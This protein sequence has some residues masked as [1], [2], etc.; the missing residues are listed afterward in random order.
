VLLNTSGEHF[1]IDQRWRTFDS[2]GAGPGQRAPQ[3]VQ[4]FGHQKITVLDLLTPE[5]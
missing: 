2:H 1:E 4:P 3:G 5:G